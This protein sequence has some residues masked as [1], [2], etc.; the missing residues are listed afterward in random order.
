MI[1]IGMSYEKKSTRK[2]ISERQQP[3]QDSLLLWR[4]SDDK[5]PQNQVEQTPMTRFFRQRCCFSL[6]LVIFCI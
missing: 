3:F 5:S 6:S 1:D 4:C 2:L